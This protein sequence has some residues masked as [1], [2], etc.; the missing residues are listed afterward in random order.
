MDQC[1][2]EVVTRPHIIAVTSYVASSRFFASAAGVC[3]VGNTM[4]LNVSTSCKFGGICVSAVNA[5]PAE[6]D[7]ADTV[8]RTSSMM[9]R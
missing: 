5:E 7:R 2:A 8:T 3:P 1:A 6:S 9:S 4:I